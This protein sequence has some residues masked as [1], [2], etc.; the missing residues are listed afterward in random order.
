MKTAESKTTSSAAQTVA[1]TSNTPFFSKETQGVSAFFGGDTAEAEPFFSPRTIQPKLTIGKP[2]DQYEVQADAVADQVVQK[3]SKGQKAKGNEQTAS[4]KGQAAS[5]NTPTVISN[6]SSVQAK[7]DHCEQE[8]KVQKKDE[9]ISPIGEQVQMKPIFDSA[10]EP[11]PDDNVQRKCADCGEEETVQKKGD[12]NTEGGAASS[13][14]SSRLSASKG[15]G[16]PLPAD[17]RTSMESAMGADFSNVRVHTGSEAVQMSQGIN[18]QAFTHGS[19]VYFNEGKYDTGSSGGQHLLAHELTH[20]VQQGA[21]SMIQRLCDPAVTTCPAVNA[22]LPPTAQIQSTQAGH[23]LARVQPL[24]QA[25]RTTLQN[26][27]AGAPILNYISQR[28]VKRA[29]LSNKNNELIIIRP[30]N[31]IPEEGSQLGQQITRLTSEIETL[32]TEVTKLDNLVK[33][34]LEALH[35]TEESQLTTLI[36]ETFPRLFVL[37]AKDIAK[38]ELDK[39]KF[40]IEEEAK[41][42]GY[43]ACV[44]SAD[45]RGLITAAQDLMA[46]RAS[47]ADKEGR[48]T[49][50]SRDLPS[51]G[52]PSPE[53]MGSNYY[54]Y[55]RYPAIIAAE[56]A[57]LERTQG[58]YILRYPIIARPNLNL[59]A[60]ATSNEESVGN[61]INAEVTTLFENIESTKENIDSERLKIWDLRNIVEM[62]S[63][64][65]GADENPDLMAAINRH[66]QQEV[67]DQEAIQMALTALAITASIVATVATAGGY[68][69]VAGAAAGFGLGLSIGDAAN[70]VQQ[71]M[72]ESQA[73]NV[74]LDPALADISANDPDLTWVIMSF[75]GVLFDALQ[76]RTVFNAVKATARTLHAAEDVVR[77]GQIAKA[78]GASV[79]AAERLMTSGSNQ[80]LRLALRETA[81]QVGTYMALQGIA[82][83]ILNDEDTEMGIESVHVDLPVTESPQSGVP[84][85]QKQPM[86]LPSWVPPSLP[87]GETF[88]SSIEGMLRRGTVP[89]LPQMD[90]VIHGQYNGS[91]HGI[92]IFAMRYNQDTGVMYMYRIEVKGGI[93]PDLGRTRRGMQTGGEW[94]SNAI[95]KTMENPRLRGLLERRFGYAVGESLTNPAVR[96]HILRRLRT[97]PSFII[98]H[99]TAYLGRLGAS[100]GGMRSHGS[101]H[102]PR[103]IIRVP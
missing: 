25:D 23:I 92:D 4:S 99:N 96:A 19:D 71:Y 94:T 52:I 9:E 97:A 98:A 40:I 63:A 58:G 80:L 12:G 93:A 102:A 15:G 34:G 11:P 72:A 44:D 21:S 53:T 31:G 77:M 86:Q 8:E 91:G 59:N 100:L 82:N 29:E 90:H 6:S 56:R 87:Y 20:T 54:D 83:E 55:M 5:G 26:A 43:N 45:K 7:C 60:I 73:K 1:K 50:I 61:A 79:V 64:D 18:A 32:N 47:I 42:Y 30:E 24:S 75:V 70:S 17:T 78:A 10:A 46:R 39:N 48:Y 27:F 57:D 28:D 2:N 33:A 3:L 76:V 101:P 89:G 88:E 36:N 84:N 68:L 41:R 66:H 74:A 37:R 103:R 62:T 35:L 16:Q 38:A 22:S 69:V 14:L 67:S 51:A 95:Q 65:L 13:D 81:E 85:V 49:Q